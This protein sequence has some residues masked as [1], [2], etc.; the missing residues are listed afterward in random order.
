LIQGVWGNNRI[1]VGILTV[2]ARSPE[3][4]LTVERLDVSQRGAIILGGQCTQAEVLRMAAEIPLRALILASL[5]PNLIAT[6]AHSPVAILVLEGFGR[7]PL[8]SSTFK[9]LSTN[10]KRDICLNTAPW[11][12]INGTR[13]ELVLPLPASGQIPAPMDS[14][15]F[16]AG[17]TVKVIRAPY[18]GQIAT[19]VSLCSGLT[20]FPSGIRAPA[21]IIRLE[22]GDQ[23]PAPLANLDVIA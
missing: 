14:S 11:N 18:Q 2:L 16:T 9:I 1:E 5:T 19:L 23:V 20:S 3:D 17:Q 4:E 21:A 7:L 8:G 13:P 6:A 15:A 22:S 10:D 12:R